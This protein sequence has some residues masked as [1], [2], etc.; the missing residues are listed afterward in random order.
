MSHRSGTTVAEVTVFPG[1]RTR[2]A[3]P[4]REAAVIPRP[5]E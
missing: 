4:Y 5:P 1:R 2:R 3:G